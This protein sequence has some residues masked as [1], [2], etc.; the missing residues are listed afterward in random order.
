MRME[1]TSEYRRGALETLE[2]RYEKGDISRKE[3]LLLKNKFESKY[4]IHSKD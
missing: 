1:S 3:Y 4:P 2:E